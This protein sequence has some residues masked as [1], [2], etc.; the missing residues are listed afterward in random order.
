MSRVVGWVQVAGVCASIAVGVACSGGTET[1]TGA[2]TPTPSPATPTPAPLQ[3]F[4]SEACKGSVALGPPVGTWKAQFGR[5][6]TLTLNLHLPPDAVLGEGEIV[7][8]PGLAVVGWGELRVENVEA[9]LDLEGV[10]GVPDP[11][12][13]CVVSET[14]KGEAK[15][16]KVVEHEKYPKALE[17]VL[18]GALGAEAA[19]GFWKS[20]GVAGAL[21]SRL[22]PGF[23]VAS[24]P[25][26][27]VMI[28]MGVIGEHAY[29]TG[30]EP[31]DMLRGDFTVSLVD[32]SGQAVYEVATSR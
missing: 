6:N 28:R 18:T 11:G 21:P 3:A 25:G 24:P 14:A 1:G 22:V 17:L 5:G 13:V 16:G 31:Q 29:A 4:D 7:V 30:L 32:P 23:D 2:S 15:P 19:D 27:Y 12:S 26:S 20:E 9:L 8:G 10:T